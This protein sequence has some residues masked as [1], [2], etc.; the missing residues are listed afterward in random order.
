MHKSVH[1]MIL[2]L[3]LST[4][5]P[6]TSIIMPACVKPLN[7]DTIQGYDASQE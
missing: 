4:Y 1:S 6:V 2:T 7:G 3:L 5:N